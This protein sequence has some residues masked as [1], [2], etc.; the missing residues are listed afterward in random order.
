[1]AFCKRSLLERE[2]RAV[3]LWMGAPVITGVFF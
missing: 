1:M 2:V 3:G